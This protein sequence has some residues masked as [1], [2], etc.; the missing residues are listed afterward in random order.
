MEDDSEYYMTYVKL[1]TYPEMDYTNKRINAPLIL[2]L[3][4]QVKTVSVS[5]YGNKYSTISIQSDNGSY[6]FDVLTAKLEETMQT[7]YDALD[8]MWE[9]DDEKEHNTNKD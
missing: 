2:R 8:S 1:D 9:D 7:I 4:T 5:E 6:F 3:N